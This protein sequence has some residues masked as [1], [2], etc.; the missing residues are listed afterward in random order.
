MLRAISPTSWLFALTLGF[1]LPSWA[2]AEAQKNT[3]THSQEKPTKIVF[4]DAVCDLCHFGHFNFF[5][6][7]RELAQSLYPDHTIHLIVGLH[8]DEDVASYKRVP[9]MTLDERVRSVQ[10]CR[11]VDEIVAGAPLYVTEEF[12][13]EHGIELVVHGDDWTQAKLEENYHVPIRLGIFRTVKYTPGISTTDLM[14]RVA[15]RYAES[16]NL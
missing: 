12:I 2:A 7:V 5:R 3:T 11:Y 6:Q 4:V 13:K 14:R 9:I 8:T 15:V 1:S 16:N 10:S